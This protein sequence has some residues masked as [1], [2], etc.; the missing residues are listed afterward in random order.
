[1][2]HVL[3]LQRLVLD[4]DTSTAVWSDVSIGCTETCTRY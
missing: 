3:D 4:T 2:T 1:M